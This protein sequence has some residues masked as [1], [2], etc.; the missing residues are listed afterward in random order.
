[1]LT[2]HLMTHKVIDD[3]PQMTHEQPA[4][5][6]SQPLERWHAAAI[7]LMAVNRLWLANDLADRP[8]NMPL[9]KTSLLP[10]S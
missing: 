5:D 2:E 4:N 8:D 3:I 1:M 7:E 6:K 9:T 10:L